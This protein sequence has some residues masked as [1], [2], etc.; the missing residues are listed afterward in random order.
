MGQFPLASNAV[1]KASDWIPVPRFARTSSAETTDFSASDGKS[2]HYRALVTKSD[3]RLAEVRATHR[4]F[5]TP[6][7]IS[8]PP[9]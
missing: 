9:S 3:A 4:I 7:R 6:G 8:T 1:E 5:V 2:A